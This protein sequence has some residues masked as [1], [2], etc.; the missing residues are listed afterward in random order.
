MGTCGQKTGLFD[1]ADNELFVGDIV[2]ASVIDE[3]GISSNCG[4]SVVVSDQWESYSDGT[5]KEKL[6]E[7][8]YFVMGIK[9]VDFMLKDSS[10]WCV[11]KMK[12]WED[13]L[14]GEHW[15]DFGFNYKTL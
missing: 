6:S 5:F 13:C 14:D 9:T 2:I 7:I 1:L 11:K 4:L 12:D 8:E 15:K 10:R 3:N